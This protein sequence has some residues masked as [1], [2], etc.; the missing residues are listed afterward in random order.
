MNK[1]IILIATIVLLGISSFVLAESKT[2]SGQVDFSETLNRK[3][4]IIEALTNNPKIKAF[5]SKVDSSKFKI[6]QAK[7]LPDP[8]FGTGYQGEGISSFN[9][10]IGQKIPFPGK[11]KLKGKIATKESETINN[12]LNTVQLVVIRR[13][14]DL[15]YD[16]FLDYKTLD[17]VNDNIELFDKIEKAALARYSTGTGDQQEVLMAQTEKYNLF[18]E[19]DKLKREINSTKAVLNT[20]LGRTAYSS[21]G[22]P[23]EPTP[24]VFKYKPDKLLALAEK[25]S[26]IL[27]AKEK[28]IEKQRLSVRLAKKN[29]YPDFVIEG[30]TALRGSGNK[31]I[32]GISTQVSIP[33]YF[34]SKQRNA[35]KEAKA[36][37]DEAIYNSKTVNYDL[38]SDIRDKYSV[39]NTAE[40]LMNLYNNALIKK[41]YQDFDLALSNYITGKNDALTVISRLNALTKYEILYWH[42]FILREKAI[43]GIEELTGISKPGDY[44]E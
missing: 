34:R 12:E 18:A 35:E 1:P 22:T 41:T 25:N 40:Q 11:L 13:V 43:A 16:L 9:F 42:Q 44:L 10:N 28:A 39:I 4:L 21:L 24:T 32:W 38:F 14:K 6:P 29:Y 33:L 37:L 31:D 23:T 30:G 8:Y 2:L 15:Y 36:N 3:K 7:S 19:K 17:I 20:V 26:P 5:E 27:K